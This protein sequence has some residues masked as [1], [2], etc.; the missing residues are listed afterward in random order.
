MASITFIQNN[1]DING[2]KGKL[3]IVNDTIN[4][5]SYNWYILCKLPNGTTITE[6]YSCKIGNIPS[7]NKAILLP[8]NF[9]HSLD[10]GGI[11][12]INIEWSGKKPI[13]FIFIPRKIPMPNL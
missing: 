11:L 13:S 1:P 3:I 9:M 8:F 10:V 6:C 12:D 5:F 2:T 4:N 7:L